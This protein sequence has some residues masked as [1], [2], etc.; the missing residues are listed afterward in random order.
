MPLH[1]V[2][3]DVEVSNV[4]AVRVVPGGAALPF[5]QSDGRVQFVLPE[6]RG[7]AMVEIARK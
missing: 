6:L 2:A 1:N 3:V 7:H 5:R 4:T